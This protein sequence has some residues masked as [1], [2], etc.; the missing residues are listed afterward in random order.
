MKRVRV[1]IF[2]D[3]AKAEPIRVRLQQ[4]GIPAE[5]HVEL[6]FARLWFI[7]KRSACVRVEVPA[8][9]SEMAQQLLISWG[10]EALSVAIRCPECKSLRVDYPQATQKFFFPNLVIGLMAGL[11]L[12]EKDYYCEGCHNMWPKPRASSGPSA[13]EPARFHQLKPW[14]KDLSMAASLGG[15]LLLGNGPMFAGSTSPGFPEVSGAKAELQSSIPAGNLDLARSELPT[16]LRDILPI[17][18]GNCSRC[19]NQQTR[20]LYNWLDYETAYAD[21]W[22]IRRRIWVSWK[23]SYYKESMPI[24]NSPEA[25]TLTDEERLTIRNWVDHGGPRGVAPSQDGPR[26][27]TERIESGRRL[28]TSVCAACHQP[29]GKGLPNTFPPLAG[30]DF[31]N[32]N[33]SR[34]IKVVIFGRQGEVVVN[35]MKFNNNMPSLPLSDQDIANVLTFVYNSFGNSGL[36]VTPEEVKVLRTQTPAPSAIPAAKNVFE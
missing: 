22:E 31:L 36:E 11:G 23:G 25:L 20:F 35:G 34:A 18:M 21:R 32:A 5:I 30:S 2:S 17:F 27:K 13:I 9:L 28:F 29:T 1:A 19:H 3:R 24:A 14:K 6:G 7:S 26:T 15:M 12:V 4:A 8:Q 16:Y 33:K 10:D